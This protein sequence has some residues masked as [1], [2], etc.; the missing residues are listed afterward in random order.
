MRSRWLRRGLLTAA[1][2]LLLL[3][4]AAC[5]MEEAKVTEEQLN[6]VTFTALQQLFIQTEDDWTTERI[7][8]AAAELELYTFTDGNMLYAAKRPMTMAPA[9]TGLPF[10]EFT[11]DPES[12]SWTLA[13]YRSDFESADAYRYRCG[14]WQN[15]TETEPEN[16][17]SG[18]YVVNSP[19]TFYEGDELT[20]IPAGEGTVEYIRFASAE[21]A[22]LR[23]KNV[24]ILLA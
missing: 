3:Q 2:L 15:L 14:I 6:A 12:G 7:E 8:S 22:I 18:C 4:L 20:Q 13:H 17:Y 24:H 1:A 9:G 11:L 10:V 23:L 21:D 5:S 16:E 19:D